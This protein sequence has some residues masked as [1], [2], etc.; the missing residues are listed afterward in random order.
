MKKNKL[1]INIIS[2][3]NQSNL[4]GLLKNNK[5]YK[6]EV[7][8]SNYNQVIQILTNPKD[9]MWEKKSKISLVWITPEDVFPEFKKLI[10]N[11]KISP[12]ILNEQVVSFCDQLKLIKKNSDFILVPSL[13]LKQ[14]IESNISLGYS[15]NRGLD[16]NLSLIN[17]ILSE[18]LKNEK[19]FYILNSNKWLSNCGIKNTYNSKLWFLM[20]CPFSNDFFKEAISDILNFYKS[21]L[22]NVKKLLILDLDDT[23][24]GGIV[25][26]VGWKKLRIGGHDYIGEAFQ[27]FQSRIKS[28]KNHGIL[29]A[30]ASKNQES[31]ALEAISKH[32]EMV[33]KIDDFVTYKINWNDKAKNIAEM[34]KELNLGLQSAVFLDDSK[35]ER[36][37]VKEILPEVYVPELPKDPT[38]YSNFLSRLRCFD[39]SH[40]TEEDKKR[41]DLYKSEFKRKKLKQSNK[42][43]SKWIETLGLEIIIE[44]INNKNSPRALQLLNKTNQM[45]LSTRRMTDNEFQ[46]WIQKK[47]NYFW[48]VRAKDKFGD[49]GIIGLLSITTKENNAYLVDFVLSCRVVGRFI[50]ETII[51]FLKDFCHK[52][53]IKKINGTYIKTKKNTLCYQFLQK[54]KILKKDKKS[55]ILLP[56]KEKINIPNIRI[57]KPK[58]LEKTN[59][60]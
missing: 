58:I 51:Q 3:F 37:R 7:R 9:K 55:F 4:V 25:G 13:I 24:W 11:E 50:E 28:L 39:I 43:L 53:N 52:K 29:L 57:I 34:V 32:P 38:D 33:L 27:D 60:S 45:N 42:S 22:G 2:S 1:S 46:K 47:T 40:V 23:L 41:V 54:L 19:N 15:I 56:N 48:T 36:E 44:N 21:S 16:Y 20:K 8:E 30:I 17:H 6:F 31:T 26:E 12:H 59:A 5:S 49:Y 18:Q 35:F 10:L 14:P